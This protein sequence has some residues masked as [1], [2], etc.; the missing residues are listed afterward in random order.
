MLVFDRESKQIVV[1]NSAV[2]WFQHHPNWMAYATGR[3]RGSRKRLFLLEAGTAMCW[4]W[5]LTRRADP[6]IYEQA[7]MKRCF[8]ALGI[9]EAERPAP[10]ASKKR[11]RCHVCPRVKD[12]KVNYRCSKCQQFVCGNHAAK[13]FV[14]DTCK[15]D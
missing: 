5:I 11:G 12:T 14:C 10:D 9:P 7:S 6:R 15:D 4:P 3:K 8:L 13:S 1:H 2:I